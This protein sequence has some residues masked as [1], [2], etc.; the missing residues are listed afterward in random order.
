MSLV[1]PG[2]IL[3][4]DD[5]RGHALLITKAL[6]RAHITNPIT[7]LHDGQDA[8]D[9]CCAT[10]Q[11]T[12][13]D[14]PLPLLMILDL[15]LPGLTGLHVLQRMQVEAQTRSLPVILV[16]AV[17]APDDFAPC[18]ALGYTLCLTKP[19]LA[20]QLLGAIRQLGLGVSI[21]SR[22]DETSVQTWSARQS[23]P[24]ALGHVF[25]A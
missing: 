16:S 9:L 23:R 5:D 20:A 7:T 10:G 8:V 4:V 6:R 24:D 17:E 13:R 18:Q 21:V 11:S 14:L 3:V 22:P 1:H 2:T 25:H 12:V 19:V 15:R